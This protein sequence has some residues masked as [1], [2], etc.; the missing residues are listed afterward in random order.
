MRSIIREVCE[1][2]NVDLFLLRERD[3]MSAVKYFVTK[4]GKAWI[5]CPQCKHGKS[6]SVAAYKGKKSA[7]LI[8]CPCGHSFEISIDFREHYRKKTLLEG[9][10]LKTGLNIESFYTKLPGMSST[11]LG[12]IIENKNCTIKDLSLGGIGL[13]IWGSHSIAQGDE[14]FVEFNLDNRKKSLMKCKV[15][16]KS[17]HNNYVGAEFKKKSDYCPELGFFLLS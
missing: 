5:E 12:Q 13:D 17:V 16:V 1:E 11:S 15:I 6:I 7:F 2:S 14:L 4:E 10:Y 3:I 8:N 9:N